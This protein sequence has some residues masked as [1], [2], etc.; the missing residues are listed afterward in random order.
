LKRFFCL[1]LFDGTFPSFFK[2][3]SQKEVRKQ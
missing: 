1:L 2:E 3:K